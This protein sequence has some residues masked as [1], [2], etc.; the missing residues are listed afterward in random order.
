MLLKGLMSIVGENN[1]WVDHH[2]DY[3]NVYVIRD[4]DSYYPK[5]VNVKYDKNKH[6]CLVNINGQMHNNCDKNN[7]VV[8]VKP[9]YKN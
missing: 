1:F 7:T 9:M 4:A 5:L 2:D 6:T 8:C 3:N